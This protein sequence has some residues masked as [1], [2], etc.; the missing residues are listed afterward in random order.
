MWTAI[1]ELSGLVASRRHADTYWGHGDS[2]N[3]AEIWAIDGTGHTRAR[4]TLDVDNHDW[5]DIAIDAAGNLYLGDIGNN[6]MDRD[7]LVVHRLKEP[8]PA[9]REGKLHVDASQRFV[10]PDQPKAP[11]GCNAERDRRFDAESLFVVEGRL[12][13]L[14]KHWQDTYTTLYRFPERWT[15]DVV[16]LERL[17]ELDLRLEPDEK[18]VT[19]TAADASPDGKRVAITSYRNLFVYAFE[20]GTFGERLQVER[21]ISTWSCEAVAFDQA[22][23]LLGG[24]NG[25]L[26]RVWLR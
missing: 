20:N 17:S 24:E 15:S 22:G 8:D 4:F 14:T 1:P 25:R 11:S 18:L 5:E 6:F 23:L 12:Y 16:A 19:V 7:D 26:W 13:L 9:R 2:W 10:Y 21:L 3:A